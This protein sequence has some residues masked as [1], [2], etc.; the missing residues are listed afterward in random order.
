MIGLLA[1]VLNGAAFG[2]DVV[3][4]NADDTSETNTGHF[5][6]VVDIARFLPLAHFNAEVDRHVRDL[7]ASQRLPG[8][9]A[10]RLP[11]DRRTECRVERLRD[12]VPIAAPL[13]VQLDKLAADLKIKPLRGRYRDPTPQHVK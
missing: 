5:L 3:D 6:I 7:R 4:F 1:G 11:G 10:I 12:G 2:R 8:I 9:D 13:L